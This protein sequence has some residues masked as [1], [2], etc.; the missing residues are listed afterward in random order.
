MPNGQRRAD[1]ETSQRAVRYWFNDADIDTRLP[2]Q[3]PDYY[4]VLY[5]QMLI[6]DV[7]LRIVPVGLHQGSRT[8]RVALDPD[9][10]RVEELVLDAL[11]ARQYNRDL[12]AATFEFIRECA[13]V[14]LA[15]GEAVYEIAFLS[16]PRGKKAIAFE[17]VR[18]QPG[19][20]I[21]TQSEIVQHVPAAV[22]QER[23]LPRE[24][25][26][27]LETV[28]AFAAP[29]QF[30]ARLPRVLDELAL[31]SGSLLPPF[32]SEIISGESRIPFDIQTHI[33][34]RSLAV[35]EATK[36]IGWDARGMGSE[37]FLEYYRLQ[38]RL[39]FK[40]F[41][42]LM[43]EG[44]LHTLNVVLER[45]GEVLGFKASLTIEGL[46]T[47]DDVE[48]AEAQLARGDRPFREIM[49]RFADV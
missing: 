17:L 14:I 24:I 34:S 9:K 22:A 8:C 28:V 27:P 38:R 3:C 21:R 46:T 48:T 26:L 45:A 35:A 2:K 10:P 7:R 6:E 15:C 36:E 43:R 41:L 29:G 44:I 37:F 12:T 25:Q 42:I 33:R 23:K 5:P 11:G 4:G 16:R 40:R 32:H 39:T 49:A 18:L 20:V 19:T 1:L 30:T 47:L 13:Q 31:L